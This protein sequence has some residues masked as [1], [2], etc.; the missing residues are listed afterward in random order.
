MALTSI[1]ELTEGTVTGNGAFDKLMAAGRAH[2][3][4]EYKEQRLT[5]PE[6][7]QVYLG[8]LE[9]SMNTALTFMVQGA[10]LDLE[11]ALLEQQVLLAQIEVQKMGLEKEK[12]AA[13]LEL[14]ELQKP[15]LQ[16]EVEVMQAQ[17][18]KVQQEVQNLAAEE[19]SIAGRTV[20]VTRQAD[21]EVI[22]GTVLVA[23]ECKLRAEFDVLMNQMTK[24]SSE[25]NLLVQKT[26]TEKAQTQA[27]GVDDNSVIGRQK[28]LYQ[29]QTDGF[30][31]DAEQKVAKTLIDTWNARRMT[32]EAT[33]AD[34]VNKLNDATIGRAVD[35]LL[36]GVG[37]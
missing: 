8:M 24:T 2:L 16:A 4:R 28:T 3:D 32:D 31:R 7:A 26:L 13:E 17:V 18:L 11:R 35:K 29:A 27:T 10:K 22:Q 20:L 33:V 36:I 30:K 23:Q 37:A 25:I 6:Y 5:G 15:K 34:S 12:L 1:N 14:L 21:N 9:S 19:L